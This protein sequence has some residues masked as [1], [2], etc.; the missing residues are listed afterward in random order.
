MDVQVELLSLGSMLITNFK[1]DQDTGRFQ[2]EGSDYFLAANKTACKRNCSRETRDKCRNK[3]ERHKD[4]ADAMDN[5]QG[6]R[7]ICIRI[8]N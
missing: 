5:K 4:L 2:Y 6:R 1:R 3:G 7:F 8:S